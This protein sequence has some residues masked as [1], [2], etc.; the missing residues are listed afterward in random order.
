MLHLSK[1]N[2]S[3]NAQVYCHEANLPQLPLFYFLVH[4]VVAPYAV[5]KKTWN[6]FN[7]LVHNAQVCCH[8][9]NLSQLQ[10]H[11]VRQIPVFTA[12]SEKGDL[13]FHQYQIT[14]KLRK[15]LKS[16]LDDDEHHYNLL[17]LLLV[18]NSLTL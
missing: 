7:F 5:I 2:F 1:I 12:K 3:L 8:Q 18:T 9:A 11:V 6:L 15:N 16:I 17:S 4:A 13:V 10:L 14:S